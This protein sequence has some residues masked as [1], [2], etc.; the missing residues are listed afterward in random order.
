MVGILCGQDIGATVVPSDL[1]A[2]TEEIVIDF[3]DVSKSETESEEAWTLYQQGVLMSEIGVR[4][5]RKKSYITKLI[6]RACKA[7]A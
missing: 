6:R 2:V 3:R 4:L 5:G 1:G 7:M